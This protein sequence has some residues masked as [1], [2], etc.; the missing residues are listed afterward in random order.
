[1]RGL[2]KVLPGIS[3]GSLFELGSA[4]VRSEP[5]ASRGPVEPIGS[6]TR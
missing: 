6:G 3:R 2:A 1:M 5:G 4:C